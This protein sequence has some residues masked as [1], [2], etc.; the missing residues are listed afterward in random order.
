MKIFLLFAALLLAGIGFAHAETVIER[1]GQPDKIGHYATGATITAATSILLPSQYA[2][3]YG[4]VATAVA[5]VGK[6]LYDKRHPD[7]HTSD[8]YDAAATVLGGALAYAA[9]KTERWRV[10]R[11][12]SSTLLIYQVD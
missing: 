5:A 3:E 7:R 1:L 2:P 10:E 6:E 8:R 11:R 4:L 9:L 12:R